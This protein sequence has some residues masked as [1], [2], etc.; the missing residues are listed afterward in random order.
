MTNYKLGTVESRF[1]DIIWTNEPLTTSELVRLC[2][3][4][5]CWKRTTTYTVLKKLSGHG[6]F[7]LRDKTV[8]S[9]IT[10]EDYYAVQSEQF[11]EDNFSGSL[12]TFIAAFT[13]RR[14]LTAEEITRIR[15]LIDDAKEGWA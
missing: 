11:V 7:Q 5:L 2:N 13:K 3:E 14:T 8:S 10:R 12:P 6:I 4:E 9:L 15:S 1:A